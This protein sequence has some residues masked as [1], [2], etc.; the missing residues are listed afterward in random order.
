V[1][2]DKFLASV[3]TAP[4]RVEPA[5]KSVGSE[6]GILVDPPS[7]PTEVVRDVTPNG[8][9][10][11][12]E[13]S[14]KR[15]YR[16]N[17][18]EVPSVTTVLGILNKP[19]LV[20]WGMQKGVQGVL[21]LF[22]LG[23]LGTAVDWG[24]EREHLCIFDSANFEL[25]THRA[26][27]ADVVDLLKSH[28]LTVNHRL[29]QAADR[30]V[31]VHDALETWAR[32]GHMPN[33]EEFPETEKGYVQGLVKFLEDLDPVPVRCEVMVGSAE[34]GFAG[35]FDLVLNTPTSEEY[36]SR[37]YPKRADKR[38]ILGPG[39][40]LCDLKTSKGVYTSHELQLAAYEIA[41][42]EGGYPETDAQAV[43]HVTADG[44][45]ELVFSRATGEQFLAI[46]KAYDV[47]EAL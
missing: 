30:G 36:T 43:I 44:K 25:I 12:Y 6:G 47:L 37:C 34:H 32:N 20:W 28:K 31:N 19:Q 46:R 29:D 23:A 10:V 21:D 39:T 35:R 4:A 11:E 40:F 22:E 14:P 18:V 7:V 5:T 9:V 16:V 17:G 41:A 13:S 15:L 45:Y 33:P 24:T 27:E 26:T 1:N 42:V 3:K 38:G 8:I 2:I